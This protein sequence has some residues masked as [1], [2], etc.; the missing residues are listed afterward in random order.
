MELHYNFNLVFL[1]GKKNACLWMLLYKI[2][3]G[4]S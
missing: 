1:A 4:F 3:K 2:L